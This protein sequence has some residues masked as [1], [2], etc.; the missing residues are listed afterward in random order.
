M[1]GDKSSTLLIAMSKVAAEEDRLLAAVAVELGREHAR[2]DRRLGSDELEDRLSPVYKKL[3]I[4]PGQLEALT[5]I[6]NLNH[7]KRCVLVLAGFIKFDG[8]VTYNHA[9][10]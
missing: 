8:I 4:A 10:T 1:R 3:R 7:D 5:G 6:V 9:G 2:H